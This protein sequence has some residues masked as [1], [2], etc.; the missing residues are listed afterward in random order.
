MIH[1]Y[2]YIY[3]CI[4]F[5]LN[6][7]LYLFIYFWPGLVSIAACSLSLVAAGG[8]SSLVEGHGLL[9][10]VASLVAEHRL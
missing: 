1:V 8:G 10:V 2:M 9:I 4:I 5:D 7:L 3:V 6:T